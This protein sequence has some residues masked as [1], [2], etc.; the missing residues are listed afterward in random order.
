MTIRYDC[1]MRK[2]DFCE[3]T[4]SK[5]AEVKPEICDIIYKAV[6]IA[7]KAVNYANIMEDYENGENDE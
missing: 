4:E 2:N 1:L 6:R 7:T 5:C 3:V